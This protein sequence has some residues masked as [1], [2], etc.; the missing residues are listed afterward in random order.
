MSFSIV[1]FLRQVAAP[2]SRSVVFSDNPR[3]LLAPGKVGPPWEVLLLFWRL[4]LCSQ[5]IVPAVCGCCNHSGTLAV[6]G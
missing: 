3:A 2:L 5:D 1:P 4:H 6:V